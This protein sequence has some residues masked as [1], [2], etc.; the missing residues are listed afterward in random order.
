MSNKKYTTAVF[1]LDGTL[2]DTLE[3]L[4][5]SINHML[6]LNGFPLRTLGEIRTFVGNGM[7]KLVE[8]SLPENADMNNFGAYSKQFTQHYGKN[9]KNKTRAYDGVIDVLCALKN[10][11]IK[12]AVVSNKMDEQTKPLCREFF[13]STVDYAV[14]QKEGIEKKPAP[15]SVFDALRTL[16]SGKEESVYIGDSDVDF[17]TAKNSGLDFIGVS[18]GFKGREF[19]EALGAKTVIDSPQELIEYF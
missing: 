14:G 4:T 13:G 1:D 12:T 2:L 8:R 15:D 18:W 3:D 7:A 11:G 10:K 16:G 9:S 17:M 19:L 5:A 6:S